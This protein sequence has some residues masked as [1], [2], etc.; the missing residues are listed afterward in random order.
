M[1]FT[2]NGTVGNLLVMPLLQV[3]VFVVVSGKLL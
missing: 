2:L 1:T 3:D